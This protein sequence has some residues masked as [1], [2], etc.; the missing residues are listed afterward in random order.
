M[1]NCKKDNAMRTSD[2]SISL[3]QFINQVIKGEG[4]SIRRQSQI[5]VFNGTVKIQTNRF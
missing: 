1:I 2:H 3:K 5:T 4:D